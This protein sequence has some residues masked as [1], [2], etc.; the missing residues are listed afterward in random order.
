M[1][2]ASPSFAGVQ[3]GNTFGAPFQYPAAT[4]AGKAITGEET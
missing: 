3:P 2:A 4:L 1:Q